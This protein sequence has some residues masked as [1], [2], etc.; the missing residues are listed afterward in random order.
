[1][2]APR[3][4]IFAF[5]FAIAA[6]A[7]V[8]QRRDGGQQCTTGPIQCCDSVQHSDQDAVTAIAKALGI[9]LPNVAI[10]VGVTCSPISLLGIGGNTCNAQTVCC[11]HNDFDGLIALGCSPININ[12]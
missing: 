8:V 12:L 9:V 6:S 5:V 1:M 11:E 2:F 3:L 10:P 7:S 4:A